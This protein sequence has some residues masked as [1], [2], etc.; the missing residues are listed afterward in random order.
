MPAHDVENYFLWRQNDAVRNSISSLAQAHFSHNQLH[1]KNRQQMHEMLMKKNIDWFKLSTVQKHGSTI[2]KLDGDWQVDIECPE[3]G[4]DREYI[5][6][7][8]TNY[9]EL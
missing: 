9:D 3:F 5:T 6:K 4:N 7:R 1:G 2:I 8:M